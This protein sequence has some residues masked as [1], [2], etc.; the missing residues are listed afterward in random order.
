MLTQLHIKGYAVIDDVTLTLGPGLN[1]LTGETG[2]GKSIV[3]GALSLLLGERAS[4]EIVR[5]GVDRAVIDGVFDISGRPE[6]AQRLDA[7]GI[8]PEDGVLVLKREILAEGRNRA[9]IN[10]SPAT[11]S[12]VGELGSVLVDM[13]GQHEHQTL[14]RREEQRRILDAFAGATETAAEVKRLHQQVA[15]TREELET[16]EARASEVASQAE[17]YRFQLT[18]ID[19]AA[20]EPG[21]EARLDDQARRLEHARELRQEAARIHESLYAGEDSVSDRLATIRGSLDRLARL[22]ASL[23]P[24]SALLESIYHQLA[25]VGRSMGEYAE[26][27]EEDGGEL[28]RLERRRE[29]LFKL[30]RKYGP[31]LDDV[32]AT[33][34][35][36]RGELAAHESA[37]EGLADLRQ[38]LA[39]ATDEMSEA[40]TQLSERR[41]AASARLEASVRE[42]LPNLGLAGAVFDV[43]LPELGDVGSGGAEGVE[44]LVSV[45]AGLEPR[46]LARVASG[47]ELS[48]VMLALKSILARVDR[49]PTLVFDEIDAGIGGTAA[50]GVALKLR[51]VAEHHQV[52]VITHLPQLASTAHAHLVVDKAVD[53]GATKTSVNALSGE[54]RVREIAR[55]L[56]GDPESELSREHARELLTSLPA[57]PPRASGTP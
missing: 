33:S 27:V 52:L 54:E 7:L 29:Q 45:N 23:A 2:A 48:R 40:A 51:E 12:M 57:S 6:L 28:D 38:R 18:E 22:D 56:G 20:V 55:M 14:L 34:V 17:L 37:T 44:F 1:A 4:A 32:I 46:P 42:V 31:T 39:S 16:A 53:N 50:T 47:G 35:R 8:V 30:K 19:E 25:E 24:Q 43:R 11:A 10:G 9:W 49:I 13:H 21:E 15:Q 36:L 5:D 3:V 26:V 41:K